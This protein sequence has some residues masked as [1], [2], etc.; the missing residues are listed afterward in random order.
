M[1]TLAERYE[2]R[3]PLGHGGMAVVE[4]AHDLELDRVV[5]V[6]LLAENLARE[7]DYRRRF[8]RE[9]QVA[10]R[11]SHPNVVRVYDVGETE[12]RPYIVMEFV[13]GENLAALLRRAGKVEP[14][15]AVELCIQAC[16]GLAAVHAVG[17]VHR[18]VKPQNLLLSGDGTLKVTDFGI[19]RLD[20]GTR[21]TLTGTL[22]GTTPYIAPEQALGEEVTP[23]ADLYSVGAVLYELLT[24]TPPRE[25]TTLAELAARFDDPVA[26][27]REL[28]P[29]TPVELERIVMRCLARGPQYRPASAGALAAELG[30]SVDVPTQPLPE[31]PTRV[32]QHAP[33]RT[34]RSRRVVLLAL[35]VVAVIAAGV[36]A[37]IVATS[38]GG[39][40]AQ[41]TPAPMPRVLPVPHS[42]DPAQE[43][44]NLAQW[45][46]ANSE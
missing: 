11:I 34:Q 30:A 1:T 18:D 31:P 42:S 20:G 12:G 14:T 10:A 21:L 27:V 39:K 5:A 6:K 38:G 43:A 37:A 36:A 25:I 8:L 40:A 2:L 4:L 28:A 23:A 9:A 7:D 46:R 26:P 44:R 13:E 15:R 35:L 41:P 16:A 32:R 22:L 19:A 33:R 17:L 29:D 3:R 45:L 24:G